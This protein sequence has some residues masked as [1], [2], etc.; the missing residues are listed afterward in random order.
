[1]IKRKLSKKSKYRNMML[2]NLATSIIL[3]E[4]LT[5]TL[6]KAKE[7]RGVTD[8]VINLGKKNTLESRRKLL[9]YLTDK[10][11]VKKIFEV[12]VPRYSDRNSGYTQIF[13]IS[14]RLGDSAPRAIIQL[15][16]YKS[17]KEKKPEVKVETK[18]LAKDNKKNIKEEKNA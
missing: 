10:N 7:L 17:I 8:K 4:R 14:P 11:A 3:Y 9:S 2:R 13:K 18:A 5:I 6:A 12:L 16:G 1:M 15:M